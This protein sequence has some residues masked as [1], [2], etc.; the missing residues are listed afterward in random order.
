MDETEKETW[1][2][3]ISRLFGAD[4]FRFL[5]LVGAILILSGPFL[6]PSE[7]RSV[8]F[9]FVYYFSVWCGIWIIATIVTVFSD[10]QDNDI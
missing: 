8:Y 10:Q 5:L 4:E 7:H 2:K 1:R 6:V 9:P 3:K